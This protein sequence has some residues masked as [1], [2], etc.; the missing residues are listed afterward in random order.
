MGRR[1]M[2]VSSSTSSKIT[3]GRMD[4]R[5]CRRV[6]RACQWSRQGPHAAGRDMVGSMPHGWTGDAQ[7]RLRQNAFPIRGVRVWEAL[8]TA[9]TSAG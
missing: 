4:G 9:G 2:V 6:G 7:S 1:I 8:T 3:R 5:K